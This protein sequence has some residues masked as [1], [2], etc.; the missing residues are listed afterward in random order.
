MIATIADVTLTLRDVEVPDTCPQ[1]GATFFDEDG[2]QELLVSAVSETA[3]TFEYCRD[4]H[5]QEFRTDSFPENHVVSYI[6][7]SS[8]VCRIPSTWTETRAE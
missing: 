3:G 8:C 6:A 2:C 4:H 1:C 5:R 7:C